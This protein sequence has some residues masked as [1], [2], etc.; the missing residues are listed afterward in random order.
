MDL[1][2]RLLMMRKTL[3][4]MPANSTLYGLSPP[5]NSMM[6]MTTR[7]TWEPPTNSSVKRRASTSGLITHHTPS[8]P[9]S[10]LNATSTAWDSPETTEVKKSSKEPRD[11]SPQESSTRNT[12]LVAIWTNSTKET[13]FAH[14]PTSTRTSRS[15]L[16]VPTVIQLFSLLKPTKDTEELLLTAVSLS[17]TRLSGTDHRMTNSPPM[18]TYGWLAFQSDKARLHCFYK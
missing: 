15:S 4:K 5:T 13:P 7:P 8:T 12:T 16:T 10:S 18:L 2:T 11:N 14:P 6:M 1:D 9:T 3:L 17:Y